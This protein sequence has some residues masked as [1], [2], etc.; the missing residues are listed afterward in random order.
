MLAVASTVA[1][2]TDPKLR[3]SRVAGEDGSMKT[4]L[5]YTY[6]H[7]TRAHAQ[8]TETNEI[9]ITDII[10]TKRGSFY[11]T[12]HIWPGARDLDDNDLGMLSITRGWE[13]KCGLDLLVIT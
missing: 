7:R 1:G 3:V 10:A 11:L 2:V 9:E 6:H 13:D 4:F 5:D 8:Q 12:G